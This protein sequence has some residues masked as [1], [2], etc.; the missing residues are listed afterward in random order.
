M[1]RH[2][3]PNAEESTVV[4]VIA[5]LGPVLWAPT[6]TQSE[7]LSAGI[8]SQLTANPPPWW[9]LSRYTISR[10]PTAPWSAAPPVGARFVDIDHAVD[11]ASAAASIVW[12]DSAGADLTTEQAVLVAFPNRPGRSPVATAPLAHDLAKTGPM[13]NERLRHGTWTLSAEL[14]ASYC[15]AAHDP[16]AVHASATHDTVVP[17]L[18][19]V[20][21]ALSERVA[22]SE[23]S[24]IGFTARFLR[25]IFVGETVTTYARTSPTA[26][27]L[28][29]SPTATGQATS[30]TATG[31]A[32]PPN[33]TTQLEI[34]GPDNTRR[35]T[36]RL[37]A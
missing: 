22:H 21:L 34:V 36:I 18:L 32:T 12:R 14:V 1:T 9:V 8:P 25:P 37:Q 19:A 27:G 10:S 5:A 3:R 16:S 4:R 23:P 28:A 17:G 26:T 31:L 15:A 11:N 2:E 6:T 29:T 13:D 33:A 35:V 24:P 7:R 30:P 20:G